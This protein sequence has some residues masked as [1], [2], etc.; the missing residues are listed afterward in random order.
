[1]NKSILLSFDLE[2]FDIPEE[3][4]QPLDND[5]KFEI[6]SRGLS[7]IIALLDRLD[8]TATFFVTANFALHNRDTIKELSKH[9]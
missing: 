3:Y 2:E 1:M 9:H 6:Y 4:G 8:I 7:N 5:I